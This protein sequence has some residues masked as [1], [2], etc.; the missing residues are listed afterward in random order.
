[1][2]KGHPSHR[3]ARETQRGPRLRKD[4]E[5]FVI[6]VG[7]GRLG[8]LVANRLSLV[9]HHVTV[10]DQRASAFSA[11]S[12]EFSGFRLEGD[13]TEFATLREADVRQADVVVVATESD[14]INLMVGQ[15]AR[16][17]FGVQ[18]VIARVDDPGREQIFYELDIET[19]C[20]ATLVGDEIAESLTTDRRLGR[21]PEK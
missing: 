2:P 11:L 1:M 3:S 20:P 4:G 16:K 19:I 9:S 15:V 13:A 7:C 8:S 21:Q 17:L 10:I 5:L 12:P 14:N 18:R 6:I